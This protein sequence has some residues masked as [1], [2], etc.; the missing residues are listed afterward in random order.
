MSLFPGPL[1]ERRDPAAGLQA[2]ATRL[3]VARAS[4][5]GTM[6]RIMSAWVRRASSEGTS[7]IP[8]AL[9]RSIVCWLVIS[10]D[11]GESTS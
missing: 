1:A 11:L 9:I 3:A 2:S 4:R 7:S 10:L 8:E 6:L 5:G